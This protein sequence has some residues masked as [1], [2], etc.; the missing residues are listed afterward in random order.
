MTFMRGLVRYGAM[1]VFWLMAGFQYWAG[2]AASAAMGGMDM[3]P[4]LAVNGIAIPGALTGALTS[5]W[6]MYALM[7]FFHAGSWLNLI[8]RRSPAGADH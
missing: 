3:A 5:M 4:R 1:P 6:L 2:E 8:G 7:G